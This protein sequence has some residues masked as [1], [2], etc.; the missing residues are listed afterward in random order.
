MRLGIRRKL[1]GTLILVGLLP[2]ALSL[3]AI[4]GLGARLRINTIHVSLRA[5]ANTYAHEIADRLQAELDRLYLL[6]HLPEVVAYTREQDVLAAGRPGGAT[7]RPGAQTRRIEAS[8]P[9]LPDNAAP[10]R[11]I[12]HNPIAERLRLVSQSRHGEY[13]LMAADRY[14]RLIAADVKPTTYFQARQAWWK[15]AVAPGCSGYISSIVMDTENHHAAVVLAVPVREEHGRQI[16]GVLKETCDIQ[17]IQKSFARGVIPIGATAQIFDSRA[18]TTLFSVGRPLV[19]RGAQARFLKN[20]GRMDGRW[21]R[22]LLR[23][24]IL[25]SAPVTFGMGLQ[26]GSGRVVVPHWNVLVSEPTALVVMPIY[27]IGRTIAFVGVVLIMLLFLVGYG[28]SQREIINPVLR[29]R[30]AAGAVGR[31]ELNVRV[32]PEDQAG[33]TFFQHDELGDLA[34]DFDNMTR[35]L[36]R[37]IHQLE[38]SDEAKKRF[39]ELA[40]H[41]LRT[42]VTTIVLTADLLR[43]QLNVAAAEGGNTAEMLHALDIIG[44][45]AR[46][47][48]KMINDILKLV[49]TDQFAAPLN[50]T[51]FDMRALILEVCRDQ[52]AFLAERRQKLDLDVPAELPFFFGDREKLGDVFSNVLTNAIRFSPDG[53][54]IHL[55]AHKTVDDRLEILI[56][57]SGCGIALQHLDKLFEPF[58]TGEDMRHHHSGTVEYGSRGLGLGLAIVRRFVEAHDG[59]VEVRSTPQGTQVFISLPLTLPQQTLPDSPPPVAVGDFSDI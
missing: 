19:A 32:M 4:L 43:R 1:I 20:R 58:Q 18:N 49:Q 14:G 37:N 59:R 7:T 11:M 21:W 27:T 53:A 57:D 26:V 34:H 52:S 5:R 10:L 33:P 38:R 17:W 9:K 13:H 41:E 44:A 51:T 48:D 29:L 54:A 15:I 56:S 45:R 16:Y 36:Q 6:A 8:W 40:G 55:A 47:L 31:G 42:P 46:R 22:E 2:L 25:G 28:I 23:G 12:L 50:R 24:P 35:Q 3:V 30:Q 39:L